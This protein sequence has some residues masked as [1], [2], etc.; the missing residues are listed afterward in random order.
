M[1]GDRSP[2]PARRVRYQGFIVTGLV[3]GLLAAAVLAAAAP[4]SPRYAPTAVLGYLVALLGLIGAVLG[5]AVAVVVES[6][7]ARGRSRRASGAD[8]PA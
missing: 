2:R 4:E 5:G 6:V 3:A 1:T 7:Q 8:D